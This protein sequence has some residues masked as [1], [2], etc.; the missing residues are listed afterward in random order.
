MRHHTPSISRA[1][2][3]VA[4]GLT[5]LAPRA[6]RADA[7]ANYTVRVIAREGDAFGDRTFADGFHVGQLNDNGQI[8]LVVGNSDQNDGAL[9]QY[10]G[11]RFIPVAVAGGPAPNGQ[12]WPADLGFWVP[13]SMNE[14]G[15]IAFAVGMEGDVY[16]WDSKAQTVIPIALPGMAAANS[17][18]FAAGGD[19]GGATINNQDE[20][21]FV[22]FVKKSGQLHS[23]AFV[24]RPDGQIQAIALPGDSLPGR[25]GKLVETGGVTINDNGLVSLAAVGTQGGPMKIYLWENG[26]TRVVAEAGTVL[27]GFGKYFGGIHFGVNNQGSVLIDAVVKDNSPFGMSLWKDGQFTTVLLPDQPLPGGGNYDGDPFPGW[28]PPNDAGQYPFILPL[29]E[30]GESHAGAYLVGEDGKVTLIVKDGMTT[31]LRTITH[32]GGN[33]SGGIAL[34]SKGQVAL[35]AQIDNGPDALLLLTPKTP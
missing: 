30:N 12:T 6:G 18:T 31:D 14:S 10:S 34:N 23:G 11:G 13:I 5:L 2:A 16:F 19:H 8:G 7:L 4:A 25:A 29:K 28:G 1:L 9:V 33:H 22:G 17:L 3:A 27:P 20:I 21:A 32:L 24:R 35:T 26:V 15:N